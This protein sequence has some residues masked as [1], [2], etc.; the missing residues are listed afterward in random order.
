M[1]RPKGSKNKKSAPATTPALEEVNEKMT[2]VE[3]EIAELE[4]QLK[5]KKAELKQ[6]KKAKENAEKA[7]AAKKAE[8]DKKAIWAAVEASGKSIE[9][10]LGFIQEK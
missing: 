10:I 4:A 9:E 7:A 8:E 2:A 6:L 5:A 3:N 1:P